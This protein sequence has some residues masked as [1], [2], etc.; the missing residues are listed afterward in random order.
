MIDPADNPTPAPRWQNRLVAGLALLAGLS[1]LTAAWG[2]Y[3]YY[4]DQQGPAQPIAFSHRLHT[5]DKQ[6]SCVMC[7]TEVL[8]STRAGIPPVETCMLC[9]CRILVDHPQ[10]RKL[11]AA[12]ESGVP[13]EWVRVNDLPELCFFQHEPH[14]RRGFDCSQCHGDVKSMD[15]VKLEH[16]FQMGFCV[17]CH[18]ENGASRDCTT[19][20]R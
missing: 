3:R 12:Y 18:K 19:C 17:Q 8:D 11:R 6:L 13:P 5:T 20:H 1:F 14:I 10:I 2:Y 9:H 7:H 16:K 4:G 15:R